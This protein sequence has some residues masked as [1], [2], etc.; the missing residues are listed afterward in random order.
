MKPLRWAQD[1]LGRS[2]NVF[3]DQNQGDTMPIRPLFGVDPRLAPGRP[4]VTPNPTG[5]PH[6]KPI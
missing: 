2:Q 5:H 1:H 4:R 3:G 6:S